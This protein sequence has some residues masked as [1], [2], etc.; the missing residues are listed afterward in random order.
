ML[1]NLLQDADEGANPTPDA[2]ENGGNKGDEGD[3]APA[4]EE[5]PA[6]DGADSDESGDDKGEGAGED[7]PA[8]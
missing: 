7:T 4:T 1:I 5:T 3:A 6:S 2:D 8:A